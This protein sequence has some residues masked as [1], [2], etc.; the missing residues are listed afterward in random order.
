M[1]RALCAGFTMLA[2]FALIGLPALVVQADQSEATGDCTAT[3]SPAVVSP[4]PE[5]FDVWVT[6]PQPIGSLVSVEVDDESGVII[7]A[8]RLEDDGR[9]TLRLDTSGALTGTYPL[10][11]KGDEDTCCA[12]LGVK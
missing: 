5:P 4:Q 6:P 12:Y 9:I 8:S 1:K 2:V 3:V 10:R 11:V 7:L